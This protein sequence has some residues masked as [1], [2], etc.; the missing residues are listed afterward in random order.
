MAKANHNLH[1]VFLPYPAPGH[2][3]PLLDTVR[4][5]ADRGIKTTVITT[6]LN[7]PNVA[8]HLNITN[9]NKMSSDFIPNLH[10]IPFPSPNVTGLPAGFEN[11]ASF[12]SHLMVQKFILAMELFKDPVEQFL[13]E[14]KPNCLVSD[15]F[16]TFS[17]N[18]AKNLG[19]PRLAF[20]VTGFFP[21]CVMMGLHEIR[22]SRCILDDDESFIVP[23][24]PHEIRLTKSQLQKDGNIDGWGEF[25][26]RAIMGYMKSYG[27]VFNTF[28]ELEPHYVDLYRKNHNCKKA[29]HIGPVSLCNRKN[30][31]QFQRGQS[32]SICEND[33]LKWLDS[34]PA[35]SVVYLSFGTLTHFKASQLREIA[36]ALANVGHNFIWVVRARDKGDET[37]NEEWLP[38]GF[39]KRVEGK[40]LIIRGWAPQV[41]ILEHETIGAF[42]THC[43]WN[44]AL[45]GFSAGVA[46]AT[47]PLHAEH[48]FIEKLVTQVLKIGVEIGS[49]DWSFGDD[50]TFIDH[51]KIENALKQIMVG[52]EALEMRARAKKLKELAHNCVKEGGSSYNDLTNLIQDLANYSCK[53]N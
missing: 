30:E 17:T 31:E 10:I 46:M 20:Q 6:P 24:L 8:K 35:N 39:E 47:W 26:G 5:F 14:V 9:E 7:A 29:W 41:M 18:L 15:L 48:F 40:G 16:F 22:E 4:L 27:D 49:K 52:E 50:G 11:Q 3:I 43:G 32:A 23:N 51:V 33:C 12:T 45:E 34:K 2:T 1:I 42:V 19:I 25:M 37:E 38:E 53:G 21:M 28:Y 36:I 13:G 44:S